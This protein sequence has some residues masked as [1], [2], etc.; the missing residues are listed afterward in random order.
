M[1]ASELQLSRRH[2]L[3]NLHQLRASAVEH[4]RIL[5]GIRARDES[6]TARAFEQHV[7]A[8]KRRMVE[9]FSV[10]AAE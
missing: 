4:G 10:A 5:D 8:G 1:I 3:G 2:N 7:L 9:T 6:R